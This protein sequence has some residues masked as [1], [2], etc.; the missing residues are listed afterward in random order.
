MRSILTAA[1]AIAL[2]GCSEEPPPQLAPESEAPSTGAARWAAVRRPV[3]STLLEHPA[4][5]IANP[6]TTGD[7]G[8]PF[9]ARVVRVHVQVGQHVSAGDPILDVV[10]PEVLD[11][12]AAV[13]G[14]NA[15]IAAHGERRRELE[16]LRA[17]GMVDSARVF[18]Q[19]AILAELEASRARALAILRAAS[20]SPNRASALLRRGTLALVTPTEGVVRS[21]DARPGEIRDPGA[22]PFAQIVGE[23][24]ARIEVRST[25]PLPTDTAASFE[26]SDGT[27]VQLAQEPI[28]HVVD[29]ADGTH[30]TWLAPANPHAALSNG[31]RGRVRLRIADENAWE[32]PSTALVPAPE[33]MSVRR[34]T[35][36]GAEPV[37]VEVLASS[38]ATAIVHGPLQEGDEVA[39][40]PSAL[41]RATGGQ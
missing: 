19:R 22:N 12:A 34:R 11:A 17:D 32:V 2:F 29:P 3:D 30:V 20:V 24:S 41:S 10:M 35:P 15:R 31:L 7:V 8:P 21:L 14:A 40:A 6:A 37:S 38:G 25:E 16:A 39:A 1:L 27:H 5:V 9:R 4:H 13:E 28:A 33:G 18:E 36:D 26:G 23:G